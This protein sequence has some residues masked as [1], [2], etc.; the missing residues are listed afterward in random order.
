MA[1]MALLPESS[2]KDHLHYSIAFLCTAVSGAL[3][4]L[5]AHQIRMLMLSWATYAQYDFLQRRM[6]NIA[7]WVILGIICAIYVLAIENHYRTA[8]TLARAQ[9]AG[10][11]VEPK[12]ATPPE[13][14]ILRFLWENDLY[15]LF[16]R[17]VK[18]IPLPLGVFV[19]AYVVMTILMRQLT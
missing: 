9:K 6:T 4:F 16:T 15:I 17:F 14:A 12:Y 18:T 2:L 13:N 1:K 10:A 11:P 19:F 8:V 5:A 3:A 7:A